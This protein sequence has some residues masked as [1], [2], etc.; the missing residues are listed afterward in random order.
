M[1]IDTAKL[2]PAHA[3]AFMPFPSRRSTVFSA[4]GMVA[5]SQPLAAQ[6]GLEILAQGGNAADAAVAT[7]AAM[8]VCEPTA[9]GI[10]GD[11]FCLFY[12]AASKSVHAVNGSG[13]A[14]RALTLEYLR[15]QGVTGDSIPLTNLNSVTCPG[16][17]AAWCTT[18]ER[19]GSM[20]LAQVLAPA[21]R[22]AREG[23]PAHELNA[24]AWKIQEQHV[25]GASDNWR[26]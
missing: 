26:E 15:S 9:T 24:E 6:A 18:I 10:G 23:V 17:A 22:M 2:H 5:T 11:A 12:D 3:P 4:K 21:I 25:K 14:P 19:F 20:S 7:A 13:R 16:T 8:N 1:P